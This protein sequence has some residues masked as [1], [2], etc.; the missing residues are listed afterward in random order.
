MSYSKPEKKL[1]IQILKDIKNGKTIIDLGD[2]PSV[3]CGLLES[4]RKEHYIKSTV[5]GVLSNGFHDEPH[6]FRVSLRPRGEVVTITN[7]FEIQPLWA[8]EHPSLDIV[9]IMDSCINDKW[10]G[11]STWTDESWHNDACASFASYDLI[12]GKVVKIWTD[13]QHTED[14]ECEC[15]TQY[16]VHLYA[17]DT[18]NGESEEDCIGD[19]EDSLID[20]NSREVVFNLI[21]ELE[22][23]NELEK[24]RQI[25]LKETGKRDATF[26]DMVASRHFELNMYDAMDGQDECLEGEVGYT[27]FDKGGYLTIYQKTGEFHVMVYNE[28]KLFKNLDD[29]EK[30][31]WGKFFNGSGYEI[32][33]PIKKEFSVTW[34]KDSYGDVPSEIHDLEYFSDDIGFHKDDRER[35]GKLNVN[36]SCTD[37]TGMGDVRI[38]RLK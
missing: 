7:S 5:I 23:K 25:K 28:D 17:L 18:I 11:D 30:W 13:Y 24:R 4:L 16:S 27:Y 31:L 21:C 33:L 34:S 1:M 15:A 37:V 2:Y 9:P 38:I 14:R 10:Y 19:F 29:A 8:R 36:E 3:N 22:R 20:T 35:I 26:E 12:K 6:K 32:D